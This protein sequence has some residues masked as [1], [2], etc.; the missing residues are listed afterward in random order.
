MNYPVYRP[1]QDSRV[2]TMSG[3]SQGVS[4]QPIG[5]S[6]VSGA[7]P[8]MAPI[9]GVGASRPHYVSMYSDVDWDI[10]WDDDGEEVNWGEQNPS[11][12]HGG[13]ATPVG[14]AWLPLALLL[15]AYVVVKWAKHRKKANIVGV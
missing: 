8:S 4:Y 5:F 14:E 11:G 15:L 2:Y 3:Y 7:S 1:S 9:S 12:W 6:S 13:E 10:D